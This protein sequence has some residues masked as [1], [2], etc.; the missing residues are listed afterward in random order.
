M[1][2]LQVTLFADVKHFD[3]NTTIS[4]NFVLTVKN[5]IAKKFMLPVVLADKAGIVK[6]TVHWD[7]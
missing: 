6:L 3:A 4:A 1:L 2:P 5:S 7:I